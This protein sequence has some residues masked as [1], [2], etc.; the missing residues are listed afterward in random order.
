MKNR[1]LGQRTEITQGK[2]LWKTEWQFAVAIGLEIRGQIKK[3]FEK[4]IQQSDGLNKG[5]KRGEIMTPTFPKQHGYFL[6]NWRNWEP[7]R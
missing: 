1:P 2:L 7:N 4:N 3:G 5:S 6:L